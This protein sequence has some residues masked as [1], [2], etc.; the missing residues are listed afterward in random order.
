MMIF[1]LIAKANFGTDG[2]VPDSALIDGLADFDVENPLSA[3]ELL[4]SNIVGL[5]TTVGAVVFIFMFFYG[6]FSW[7]SAGDDSSKIGKARDRMVQAVIGLIIMV[8][9]YAL[10]GLIGT[11]IGINILSPASQIREIFGLR[12]TAF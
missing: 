3:T 9:G 5:L 11:M 2:L 6:A 4:V 1:N 7:I 10:I 8:A 12:S